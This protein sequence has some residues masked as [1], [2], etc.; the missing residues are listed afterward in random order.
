MMS[1][2]R[3]SFSFGAERW[4]SII[5]G[6]KADGELEFMDEEEERLWKG[7]EVLLET[8]ER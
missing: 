2:G 1:A 8:E 7:N 4:R 3:L 6:E 5:E